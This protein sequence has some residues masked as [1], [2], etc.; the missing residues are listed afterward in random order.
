MPR[1]LLA[2]LMGLIIAGSPG[3]A[4]ATGAPGGADLSVR[5]AVSPAV[6]QPGR[7]IT[8]QV[9]VRN[10]GPGA[11]VLPVLKVV[12]P[13]EVRVVDVDV[14]TCKPG[15]SKSEIVCA[16]PADVVA[17]GAGG[18]TITG[19]VRPGARGP[20]RAV[21]TLTSQT[22]DA[23]QAD[24]TNVNLVNVD[25]GADLGLRLSG[26]AR[27]GR[28]ALSAVVRNQGPGTVRDARIY[29]QTGSASLLSAK[30]ARCRDRTGYVACR[31]RT[32]ASGERVEVQ[33]AL[34]AAGRPVKV[35]AN[36][37]S[38]RFGDRRPSDNR[39]RMRIAPR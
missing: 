32:I 37:F 3:I 28:F 35:R 30:G 22:Q 15:R 6:A 23:N 38:T 20:L 2:G 33:L 9:T 39:A 29:V 12:L 25:E 4:H 13:P 8:Y 27:S 31:V 16:S 17:G 11:A 26:R 14:A 7:P 1:R 21:A 5:T 10:A 34:R 18:V 19:V 24:N 36:V